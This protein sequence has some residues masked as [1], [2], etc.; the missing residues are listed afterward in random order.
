MQ[1][2]RDISHL[3]VLPHR[4]LLSAVFATCL[5]LHL[6]YFFWTMCIV[7][8]VIRGDVIRDWVPPF[9]RPFLADSPVG[10]SNIF[11]GV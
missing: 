7:F 3:P 4:F 2:P 6:S 8:H 11:L 9:D 1:L 10:N 5:Y